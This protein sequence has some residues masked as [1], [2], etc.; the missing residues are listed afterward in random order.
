[1]TN[2]QKAANIYSYLQNPGSQTSGQNLDKGAKDPSK[3]ERDFKEV[4]KEQI[5]KKSPAI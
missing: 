2:I 4:L 5:A 3:R 1:M